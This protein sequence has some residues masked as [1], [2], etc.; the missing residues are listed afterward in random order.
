M[1][2]IMDNI[3]NPQNG[4]GDSRKMTPILVII[5]AIALLAGLYFFY[6]QNRGAISGAREEVTELPD[7]NIMRTAQENEIVSTFPKE[8]IREEGVSIANSYSINYAGD[9]VNLP[10]VSFNSALSMTE[11]AELYGQYLNNAGWTLTHEADPTQD[12]TFFY[13]LKDGANLNITFENANGQVK[14][15]IAYSAPIQ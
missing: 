7:G 8:L 13:G 2:L 3:S 4:A 10:V 11:N 1:N 5:V 9:N 6:A 14:V 15:T 12:V